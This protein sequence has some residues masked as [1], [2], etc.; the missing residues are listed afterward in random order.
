MMTELRALLHELLALSQSQRILS[1]NNHFEG[2]DRLTQCAIAHIENAL[3]YLED[4]HRAKRDR[5]L[6]ER[7]DVLESLH[8]GH[9]PDKP[10][11]GD[12][13]ETDDAIMFVPWHKDSDIDQ[14][15]VF[16][17]KDTLVELS[18]ENFCELKEYFS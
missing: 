11:G 15:P 12:I 7:I 10:Y 9:H 14:P 4:H 5:D 17:H 16:I 13:M 2:L 1:Q 18:D 8:Y 3:R 6:K